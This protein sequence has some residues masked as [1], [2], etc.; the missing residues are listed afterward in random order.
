MRHTSA[1]GFLCRP[2]N[3]AE[4]SLLSGYPTPILASYA[5]LPD[6]REDQR[7]YQA[8]RSQKVSS[9]QMLAMLAHFMKVTIKNS[10]SRFSL[11]INRVSSA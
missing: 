5:L 11:P 8:K 10:N 4:I 7:L 1:N 2:E 6:F 9:K 3:A